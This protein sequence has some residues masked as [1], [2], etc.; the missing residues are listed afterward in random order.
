MK[1][2]IKIIKM[3]DVS[4]WDD[5]VENTYN[6]IYS[7]QQQDDCK[8]RGIVNLTVPSRDAA[9]YDFENETVPEIVNGNEMG[10]SFSAWL[11][12]DPNK[13]LDPQEYDYELGMWWDRNF[14]PHVDMVAND[15]HAK[16]LVE[17]GEYVI[18][19]DW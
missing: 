12:R 14:Y 1:I 18:N 15:L 17:A 6:R 10:V 7:F 13:P 8:P 11:D 16:G 9:E 3:I 2:K 19:I 4:D 5:L